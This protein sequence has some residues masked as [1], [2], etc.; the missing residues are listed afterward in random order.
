M[1]R[2]VSPSGFDITPL[3]EGER[4]RHA[5]HL[6][7]Q[8]RRILLAHATEAPFCGGL[9]E[10]KEAGSYACALCGLPLFSSRHKFESGTGWPSFYAPFDHAHIRYVH[11]N[12]HG[13]IRTEIRCARC[14]GHLGHVF[15]DGPPPTRERYCLNSD[16]MAFFPEGDRPEQ[17]IAG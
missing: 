3:T 9:L 16:A 6:T 17:R 8:Q 10:N 15:P 4:E 7:P 13:M 12:S 11:D 1:S 14:D 5:S 2:S